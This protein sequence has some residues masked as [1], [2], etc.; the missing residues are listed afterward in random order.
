MQLLQKE[1]THCQSVP[2]Q[3]QKH[4]GAQM[5]THQLQIPD[6]EETHK[7]SLFYTQGQNTPA[8]ILVTLKVNGLTWKWSWTLEQPFQ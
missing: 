2:Q 7:Y 4:T 5:R 1:R 8:P 3:N 6:T